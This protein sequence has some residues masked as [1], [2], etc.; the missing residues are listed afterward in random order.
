M[1]KK[2][3]ALIRKADGYVTN[4]CVWDTVTYWNDLPET[5]EEIECPEN[6]CPGWF[7]LDNNWL[8]PT[9]PDNGDP[10]EP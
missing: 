5:I 6:V 7:F 10:Q 1:L 8:P 9:I 4:V 2:R 3:F